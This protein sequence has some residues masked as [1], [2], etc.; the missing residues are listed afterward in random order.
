[1]ARS[2]LHILEIYSVHL[3]TGH[4]AY[5]TGYTGK[6]HFWETTLL[7]DVSPHCYDRDNLIKG[8]GNEE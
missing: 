8:R 6:D 2:L 3:K 1:M 7:F 5:H 4:L